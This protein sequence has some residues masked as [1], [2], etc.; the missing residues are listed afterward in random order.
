[1]ARSLRATVRL[2]ACESVSTRAGPGNHTAVSRP[3]H[4]AAE[5]NRIPEAESPSART[6]EQETASG[7][8]ASTPA[9]VL[10]RVIGAI[11]SLVAVVL[12]LVVLAYVLS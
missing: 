3:V 10:L 1:M 12:A 2:N 9:S 5:T 7:R 6:E 8:T 11:A 4:T